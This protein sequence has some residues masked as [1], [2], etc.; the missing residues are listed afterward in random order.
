[1]KNIQSDYSAE[2]CLGVDI[3]SLDI[4]AIR[5]ARAGYETKHPKSSKKSL[6][7]SQFLQDIGLIYSEKEITFAAI[8]LLGKEST[9]LR[10]LHR[11]Q[12]FFEYRSVVE[13]IG[14]DERRTWQK[15]IFLMLDDIWNSIDRYNTLTQYSE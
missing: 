14:Y 6:S 15:P 8:I 3:S 5:I 7:D 11:H 4:D 2:V 13:K 12:V 9:I 10:Y 1:M